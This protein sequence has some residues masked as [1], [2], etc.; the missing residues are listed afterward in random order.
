M[1]KARHHFLAVQFFKWYVPWIIN[2]QF[3]KVVLHD[4]PSKIDSSLLVLSNHFSWWDPFLIFYSNQKLFNKKFFVMMLEAEL[5]KRPLLARG[6]C[7]SVK[8]NSRG[9]VESLNY[10]LELLRDEKNLVL[11]FPQGEIESV[12][13]WHLKFESGIRSIIK[14]MQSEPHIL[15]TAT[16]IEYFSQRKPEAHLYFKLLETNGTSANRNIESEY[17]EFYSASKKSMISLHV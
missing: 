15:F 12:Q 13:V 5:R 16:F 11:L 6:G 1:I 9:V 17:N 2:R 4:A 14:R 7:Y 10:T 3:E 8:K